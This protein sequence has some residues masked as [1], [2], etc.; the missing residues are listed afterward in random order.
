MSVFLSAS[1]GVNLTISRSQVARTYPNDA[2]GGLYITSQ[3]LPGPGAQRPQTTEP[4]PPLLKNIKLKAGHTNWLPRRV[5]Q[6]SPCQSLTQQNVWHGFFFCNRR[7][8]VERRVHLALKRHGAL[9]LRRT[10]LGRSCIKRHREYSDVSAIV[11]SSRL[12][13]IIRYEMIQAGEPDLR[14]YP[15][16][17]WL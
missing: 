12:L 13:A 1:L 4:I 7:M 14:F 17:E 3:R 5:S 11:T 6:Y 8:H 16:N 10:C 2:P 9:C 15:M